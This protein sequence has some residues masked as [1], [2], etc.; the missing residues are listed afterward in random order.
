MRAAIASG[1]TEVSIL[2][3]CTDLPWV[4]IAAERII[5]LNP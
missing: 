5:G 4:T 3:Y 1:V 2:L